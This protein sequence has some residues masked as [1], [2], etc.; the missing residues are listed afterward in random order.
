MR[1]G[2]SLLG[3]RIMDDRSAALPEIL[4]GFRSR[5]GRSRSGGIWNAGAKPRMP[6]GSGQPVV[7]LFQPN[8]A[9]LSLCTHV[10]NMRVPLT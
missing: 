5:P 9:N 1:S 3:N 6:V 8:N 2:F 10:H 4:E 7:F